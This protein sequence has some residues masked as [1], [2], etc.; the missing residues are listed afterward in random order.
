MI[1]FH[2]KME[3]GVRVAALL[4]TA[5]ALVKLADLFFNALLSCLLLVWKHTAEGIAVPV[6]GETNEMEMEL[7]TWVS[8]GMAVMAVYG[9]KRRLKAVFYGKPW[10]WYA[11]LIFPLLM[12]AIAIYAANWGASYGVFF[13][14]AG[15]MGIYYDQIFSYVGWVVLSG[16]SLFAVIVSVFGM[17]RIYV[18][19]KKAQQYQVQTAVYQTL[20]EQY[21]QA[22]RLRHDLK[23]HV[24]ALRGLWEEK[25]WEKLGDYLKR[26]EDSAQLGMSGEAAGNRAVDALLCQKRKLAEEKGIDWEC[27]VRVPKRC[28]VDEFDLC[29]LFGNLLDN[30][31][32]ACVRLQQKERGQEQGSKPFIRV[33]AGNVKSC[34][35]LE[36]KNSMDI[37]EKQRNGSAKEDLQEHGIGLLNV[38]DVVRRYNGVM[39]TERQEG[40]FDISILLPLGESVYDME[41]VV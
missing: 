27:D 24:L 18:E 14:S 35:L 6:L 10:R 2:N 39:N 41:R 7:L 16:L 9:M 11:I 23:N 13:R 31:L 30:A 19:Q 34:F 32:E 22:E 15:D 29:V 1:Q 20:E 17:D 5:V 21:R 36:V 26:M 40:I 3:L 38:G 37:G 12:V 4:V 25:A 28:S 8:F 33:Q